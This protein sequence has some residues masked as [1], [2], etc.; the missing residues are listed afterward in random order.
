[1]GVPF[2]APEEALA[3]VIAILG[4]VAVRRGLAQPLL[5]AMAG[6][7]TLPQGFTLL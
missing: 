3:E 2:H 6:R 4:A 7:E 5:A 1:M